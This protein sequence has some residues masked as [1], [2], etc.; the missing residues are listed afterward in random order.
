MQ[1]DDAKMQYS[2]AVLCTG[3]FHVGGPLHHLVGAVLD[4]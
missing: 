4:Q 3:A 2:S 1:I